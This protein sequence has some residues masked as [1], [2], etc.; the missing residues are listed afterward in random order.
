LAAE[1]VGALVLDPTDL[2]QNCVT[3]FPDFAVMAMTW[4]DDYTLTEPAAKP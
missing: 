4:L 3:A 1:A 2:D